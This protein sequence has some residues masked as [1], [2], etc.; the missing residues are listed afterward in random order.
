M[1]HQSETKAHEKTR[2][3][4]TCT[5]TQTH[6][7][8]KHAHITNPQKQ[9]NTRVRATVYVTP[10]VESL[11]LCMQPSSKGKSH[12]NMQIAGIQHKALAKVDLEHVQSTSSISVNST[13]PLVLLQGGPLAAMTHSQ[14]SASIS[15]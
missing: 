11:G 6:T 13:G 14:D 12:M 2:A 7:H 4:N 1:Q 3:A 8:T 10:P 15:S 9:T 5:N